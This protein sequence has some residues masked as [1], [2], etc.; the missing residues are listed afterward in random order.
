MGGA[1]QGEMAIPVTPLSLS[2]GDAGT[3][4]NRGSSMLGPRTWI[5]SLLLVL[6]A[7]SAHPAGAF[8]D[9]IKEGRTSYMRYCASCHGSNADGHGFVARALAQPPSDLRHLGE[10]NDTSLLVDRLVRVIDGRRLV[11]AHGQR[12]MPV[13]GERFDDIQG[14]GTPREKG[15]RDRINAIVAYL[16]SIQTRAP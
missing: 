14:E 11:A 1:R 10:G 8:G 6:A 5:V 9:E 13:W 2:C 15:V 7:I 12:E 3:A 4:T 16:V